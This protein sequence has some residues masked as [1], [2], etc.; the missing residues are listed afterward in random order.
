MGIVLVGGRLFLKDLIK[1]IGIFVIPLFIS[2]IIYPL[3]HE[4]G[5]IVVAISLGSKVLE[6]NLL[7]IPNI[8][9]E[10][11]S[12][13]IHNF[14]IGFGGIILPV[15]IA[16]SIK[17]KKFWIWYANFILKFICLL[18]VLIST[19]SIIFDNSKLF[20]QDDMR[21]V[22]SLLHSGK[23]FCLIIILCLTLILSINIYRE[24]LLNRCLIY[25]GYK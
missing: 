20:E 8:I 22:I 13:N 11:S 14:L 23:F 2:I 17:T 4:I 7:P 3:L 10:N 16:M 18:S 15:M 6:I 5:H 12:S 21:T 25:F 24:N 19:L 1:N 9:C